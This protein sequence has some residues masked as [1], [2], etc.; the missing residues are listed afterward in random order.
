MA[1]SGPQVS[2]AHTP[3]RLSSKPV[4]SDFNYARFLSW[5][6]ETTPEEADTAL[7]VVVVTYH[8]DWF[9][10]PDHIP[11]RGSLLRV[12]HCSE[13]NCSRCKEGQ[14]GYRFQWIHPAWTEYRYIALCY[15][16]P[17][18][19][20]EECIRRGPGELIDLEYFLNPDNVVVSQLGAAATPLPPRE[21]TPAASY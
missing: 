18:E 16:D 12:R 7:Q 6:A 17:M 10:W 13:H 8:R 19:L 2:V 4:L 1:K 21:S 15:E 5:L 11:M 20:R 3:P 9:G 14:G